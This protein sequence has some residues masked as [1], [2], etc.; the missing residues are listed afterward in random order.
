MA[1]VQNNNGQWGLP[2]HWLWPRGPDWQPWMPERC[3]GT[4]IAASGSCA[5]QTAQPTPGR[6]GSSVWPAA[7]TT[8]CCLLMGQLQ[9][10][11]RQTQCADTGGLNQHRRSWRTGVPRMASSNLAKSNVAGDNAWA[12]DVFKTTRPWALQNQC[13]DLVSLPPIKGVV[14]PLCCGCGLGRGATHVGGCR[15]SGMLRNCC[16]TTRW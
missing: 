13:W 2:T 5:A 6:G 3:P 7:A 10:S 16:L 14:E 4:H 11:Q 12:S 1:G 9:G 8:R 15:A